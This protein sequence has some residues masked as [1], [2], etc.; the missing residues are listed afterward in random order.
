[1]CAWIDNLYISGNYGI[2]KMNYKSNQY[3]LAVQ[4]STY[5]TYVISIYFLEPP[6]D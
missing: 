6:F 4:N 2:D 3:F 1:M 5:S